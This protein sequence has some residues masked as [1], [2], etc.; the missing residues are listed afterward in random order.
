M[1][2]ATEGL[3]YQ[4]KYFAA[5]WKG[6]ENAGIKVRGAYHFGH[7]NEAASSQ[8]D[9]FLNMV[10][11]LHAGDFLVLDIEAANSQPPATVAA[12]SSEFVHL[13][14]NRTQRPVFVYT[15]AW[16]WNPQAGGSSSC[17]SFPLWVS[18]YVASNPP[19][20]RGW[21]SWTFWQ[22]TDKAA[23]P[24]IAGGVDY[25]RFVGTQAALNSLVGLPNTPTPPTPPAPAPPPPAPVTG[26]RCAHDSPKNGCGSCHT[27]A[28]VPYEGACGGTSSTAYCQN[29]PAGCSGPAP[30]PP[31][32]APVT[33]ARCEH[34]SPMNGCGSCHTA[35]GVPYEGACGGTSSTAYC[36][37]NP[38]GCPNPGS[39]HMQSSFM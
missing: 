11:P 6:M 8:V 32:P 10:G 34:N 22:F 38:A 5:N 15:G 36:Q 19:I 35:A 29:N 3:G 2:K 28:G 12:F 14:K 31:P 18:G 39:S 26:A 37:N 21:N 7:P 16:F 27:A 23:V 13:L 30:A 20:P 9:Y 24:G 25:S 4:D 33:G 17:A 1:A